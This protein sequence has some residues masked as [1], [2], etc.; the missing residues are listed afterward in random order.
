MD[1]T[2]AMLSGRRRV[3]LRRRRSAAVAADS[4][5][6]FVGKV[7]RFPEKVYLSPVLTTDIMAS[8]RRLKKSIKN[9]TNELFA[10]CIALM[11]Q[12]KKVDE[13]ALDAVMTRILCARDE[14]VCR[15]SHT[16][17]GKEREFYRQFRTAFT[18]EINTVVSEIMK[19]A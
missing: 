10:E 8:R 12:E 11:L 3:S 18:E 19:L 13:G 14:F 5:I 7:A 16:E 2:A 17:R 6:F 9:I 4:P 1:E 15:I